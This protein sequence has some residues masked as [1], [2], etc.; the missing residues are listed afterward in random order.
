MAIARSLDTKS[1][2]EAGKAKLTISMS[3]GT[4]RTHNQGM[5]ILIE[6][7]S[8]TRSPGVEAY[9]QRRHAHYKPEILL[10]DDVLCTRVPGPGVGVI[11][12][13][14]DSKGPCGVPIS[15]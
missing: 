12:V 4:S 7:L 5:T 15:T 6:E 1:P 8:M 3:T 10:P 14:E 11:R 2:I 13:S 9:L